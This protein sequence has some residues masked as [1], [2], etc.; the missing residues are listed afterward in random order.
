MPG[1]PTRARAPAEGQPGSF[2]GVGGKSPLILGHR[3]AS[4]HAPENSTAAFERAAADG[5]DGVEL[6]VLLCRTG[7]PMVFHD[8]DLA[9][10]GAG[11]NT[12][13]ADLA[14]SELRDVRLGSGASIPT[15]AEA[16]EA[17][18]PSMLVNVELK[19]AGL[20]R[21]AL[22][23]LVAEVAAVVDRGRGMRQR[24]LVSSFNPFALWLWRRR[25]PRVPF[26]L[27]FERDA[28]PWLRQAWALPLLRPASA[29]PEHGL[30]T[31]VAV[32]RWHAAGY[33]VFA[34][35]VDD[36][37]EARRLR[38]LGVDGLITNDPARTRRALRATG[39]EG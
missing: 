20:A 1:W 39:P 13:I 23:R 32:D 29:H 31:P 12:R 10:L 25:S 37:A 9:R 16:F 38:D 21:A 7:E 27:L 14:L 18:G 24:V 28:P 2:Q 17:C 5:A 19:A 8:D 34:W 3:G 26:G 6:D 36:A 30:C 33:A 4:A 11:R 35:T 15:L 22:A